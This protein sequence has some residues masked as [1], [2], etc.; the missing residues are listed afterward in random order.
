MLPAPMMPTRSGRASGVAVVG[1]LG[2]HAPGRGSSAGLLERLGHVAVDPPRGPDGGVG[3]DAQHVRVVVGRVRL[4]TRLEVDAPDPGRGSRCTRCGTPRHPGTSRSS[5]ARRGRG[6]RSARRTSPPRP[7]RC[8]RAMPA[9]HRVVGSQVPESLMLARLAPPEAA[10]R[11]HQP[12]E[13]PG[14]VTRMEHHQ[15]HAA[16]HR[17]LDPV[18]DLVGHL[19]MGDVAP[20]EQH[21]RRRPGPRG[22][23]RAPARRGSRSGHRTTRA[24]RCR[25]AMAPWMP[26]G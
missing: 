10:G 13:G 26:A 9:M 21:V 6:C 8:G 12:P 5:A 22:S 14:E 16:Q 3:E 20:P 11:A 4:V 23:G 15:A 18:D 19:V 2:A 1:R 25:A 7:A 24:A 17:V